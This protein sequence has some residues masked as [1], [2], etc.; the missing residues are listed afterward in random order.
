MV[1]F[2]YIFLSFELT[3]LVQLASINAEREF[4]KRM[5]FEISILNIVL[6]ISFARIIRK[7]PDDWQNCTAGSE[8]SEKLTDMISI[9]DNLRNS[10]A[11]VYINA[12]EEISHRMH[13][14]KIRTLNSWRMKDI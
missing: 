3:K 2:S 11:S 5:N 12:K 1:H 8:L 4:D 13:K 6:F 14:F 7:Y 10:K 9:F